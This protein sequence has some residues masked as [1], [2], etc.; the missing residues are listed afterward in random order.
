MIFV[1]PLKR[2]ITV[3]TLRPL[4]QFVCDV[5]G[6]LIENVEDGYVIYRCENYRDCGFKIIHQGRCD[7]NKAPKS[8]ALKEFLGARGLIMLT[9]FLSPGPIII[10][11]THPEIDESPK[12]LDEFTDFF[13]RVQVPFYEEARQ[14]FN[15][16]G[17]LHEFHGDN[18]LFPYFEETLRDICDTEFDD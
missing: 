5:C 13:R 15:Q 10:N 14:K 18:E 16:P 17:L 4:E 9:G 12:S 2:V 7:D 1:I 3:P 11:L 8:E 6:D